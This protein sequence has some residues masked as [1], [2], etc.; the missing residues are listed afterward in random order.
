MMVLNTHI[1]G[2]HISFYSVLELNDPNFV[3]LNSKSFCNAM[4]WI[5]LGILVK[6]PWPITNTIRIWV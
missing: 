5:F 4:S 1:F 2:S 3:R 6:V